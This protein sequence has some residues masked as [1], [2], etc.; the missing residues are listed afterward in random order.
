MNDTTQGQSYHGTTDS[1]GNVSFNGDMNIGDDIH[2]TVNAPSM[3]TVSETFSID[4]A[5]QT[6]SVAMTATVIGSIFGGLG[7]YILTA[8]VVIGG[9]ATI[10][11][12]SKALANREMY[13]HYRPPKY[14]E[15]KVEK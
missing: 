7:K 13:P 8:A 3:N 2:M 10:Y 11:E 4:Y 6:V 5:S 12:V 1:S 14:V 15:S 9:T